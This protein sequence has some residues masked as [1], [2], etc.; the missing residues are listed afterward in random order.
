M[1]SKPQLLQGVFPFTGRGL[2]CPHSLS[3]ELTYVVPVGKRTHPTINRPDISRS[4]SVVPFSW[5]HPVRLLTGF[6]SARMRHCTPRSAGAETSSATGRTSLVELRRGY[7]VLLK[8]GTDGVGA[9]GNRFLGDRKGHRIEL[10]DTM[11]ES[12]GDRR[13]RRDGW[14]QHRLLTDRVQ[15][16]PAPSEHEGRKVFVGQRDLDIGHA[17]THPLIDLG[18]PLNA[19]HHRVFLAVG[20]SVLGPPL[21]RPVELTGTL[22]FDC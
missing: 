20:R 3:T 13:P 1:Y 8:M 11:L 2:N 12:I 14:R 7:F 9:F 18:Q 6:C 16:D 21:A 15:N 10:L 17:R 19:A 4:A 5:T 22:L